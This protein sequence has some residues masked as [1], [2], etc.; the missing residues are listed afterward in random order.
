MTQLRK[1]QVEDKVN[2]RKHSLQTL[3]IVFGTILFF[4]INQMVTNIL[5]K[6]KQPLE[7]ITGILQTF[8]QQVKIILLTWGIFSLAACGKFSPS[9]ANGQII[10]L[11]IR[12]LNL[13]PAPQ[14]LITFRNSNILVRSKGSEIRQM[15]VLI[16]YLTLNTCVTWKNVLKVTKS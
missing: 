7:T 16:L 4:T 15:W 14:Q 11:K 8:Y 2:Y 6:R 10:M 9:C 12:A 1:C 3:M 13:Q 5:G